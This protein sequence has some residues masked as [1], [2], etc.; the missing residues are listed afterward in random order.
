MSLHHLARDIWTCL[1]AITATFVMTI[2]ASAQMTYEIEML[3]ADPLIED[4]Y[5]VFS[6]RVLVIDPGDTVIFRATNPGHNSASSW[7]MVPDGV[8]DWVGAIDEEVPLT[9]TVPGFYGYA[10]IPHADLGMVGLIIVRG[11]GMMDNLERAKATR[12]FEDGIQIWNEIWEEVDALDL[13]DPT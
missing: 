4:R 1:V 2:S 3:D 9:L 13:A 11:E 5:M 12:Q 7:N 8:E 6:P 10:C